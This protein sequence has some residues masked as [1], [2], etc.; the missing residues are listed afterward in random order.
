MIVTGTVF[1]HLGCGWSFLWHS[2]TLQWLYPVSGRVDGELRNWTSL[3]TRQS[4]DVSATPMST[5]WYKVSVHPPLLTSRC[6]LL[7]IIAAV[8]SVKLYAGKKKKKFNNKPQTNKTSLWSRYGCLIG[9]A[10]AGSSLRFPFAADYDVACILCLSPAHWP[11]D[12]VVASSNSSVLSWSLVFLR[13]L[14]FRLAETLLWLRFGCLLRAII[15]H[16]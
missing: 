6:R 14:A 10:W 15:H 2:T 7:T 8:I 1:A 9:P 12:A 4:S 13:L 3:Q 11:T 5:Q 16:L